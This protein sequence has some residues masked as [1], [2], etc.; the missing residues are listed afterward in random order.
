M[1]HFGKYSSLLM[2]TKDIA[3]DGIKRKSR[4]YTHEIIRKDINHWQTP[5]LDSWRNRNDME[6]FYTLGCKHHFLLCITIYYTYNSSKTI[7]NSSKMT[8]STCN[9]IIKPNFPQEDFLISCQLDRQEYQKGVMC[10]YYYFFFFT[11]LT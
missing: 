8:F 11:S 10:F 6:Y 2:D 4:A 1:E 7:Y 9:S 5:Y 3:W